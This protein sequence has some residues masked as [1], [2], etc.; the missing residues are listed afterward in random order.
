MQS[1]WSSKLIAEAATFAFHVHWDQVRQ[2][3]KEPYGKHLIEVATSLHWA[4]CDEMTVAAG[5]LHDSNED[6]DITFGELTRRF[7]AKV[8]QLV[9]EVTNVSQPSMGNRAFR[10]AL[11]RDHVARASP[12]GMSIKLAD[13][14]SNIRDVVQANRSFARVYI[15]EKEE[16]LP[17]LSA[18]NP[19]LFE[20]AKYTVKRAKEALVRG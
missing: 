11:D 14:Q 7:G 1:I 18:G 6:Q 8:A 12:E 19:L 9:K 10:K 20:A 5:F 17:L 3:N 16:L 4:G 13:I 2:F 15:P